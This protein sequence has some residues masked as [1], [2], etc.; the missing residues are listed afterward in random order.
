MSAKLL[1][2][3]RRTFLGGA[4][5]TCAVATLPLPAVA[6]NK[7][8]LGQF[9]VTTFSDGHIPLPV[10]FAAPNVDPELRKAAWAAAGQTGETFKSPINVTLIKTPD[11]LIL[12]DMGSGPR[13]V[14]T[15]GKLE[16][17]LT[18][19]E[20]DPADV[21]KV[22]ITHGHPDHLWG[23][24]ND[25]DELTFPEAT[26][27]V[28]KKEFAFWMDPDAM[29][30]L[31]EDRQFFAVGAKSRF[32]TIEE[33]I[34]FIKEDDE[35]VSGIAVMETNG[36]TQGHISVELKSGSD[37]LVV[38]GDALTNP[39]ISFEHPDWQPA[40]DHL[41]D[42]AVKTRKRLLDRLHASKAKIIGYHLPPPGMG[43][44]VKKGSG[45]GYEALG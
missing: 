11:D 3:S 27:Y 35:I 43:M 1:Q 33:R 31:R 44:V 32:E 13:F 38:L 9:E 8:T 22:I 16:E 29:K 4:A 20:I 10:T 37:T 34:K 21:T 39:V 28:A 17:A 12:V 14:P 40:S 5:A 42:V 7:V 26:Y 25:F 41:P 24:V 15:T 36:H 30:S 2:F 19:A 23:A 18:D 6:A 45:Y